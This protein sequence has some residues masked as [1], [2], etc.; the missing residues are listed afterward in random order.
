MCRSEILFRAVS[1][2]FAAG[3][4]SW[5]G[6]SPLVADDFIGPDQPP[7][8]SLW[9]PCENPL[10]R[11]STYVDAVR[12]QHGRDRLEEGFATGGAVAAATGGKAK[13]GAAVE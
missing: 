5:L 9:L 1:W 3:S 11:G 4:Q 8:S 7:M 10:G 6:R 13:G 12:V 2:G